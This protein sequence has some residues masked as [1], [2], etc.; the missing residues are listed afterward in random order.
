MVLSAK[1]T[2]NFSMVGV[3]WQGATPLAGIAVQVRTK[4]SS[5]K[6]TE[7]TDMSIDYT[8]T[9]K[10]NEPVGTDPY[11]VGPS[12]GV[13]VTVT[14]Q[15]GIKIN[16][17]KLT[18]I[19]P[20]KQSQDAVSAN[21]PPT[22]VAGADAAQPPV[23]SRAAW[24][25]DESLET[26]DPEYAPTIKAA[27]IHHTVDSNDYS[28]A[29]VPGMMRS[30]YYYHAVTRGW[31]DIGYNVVVDKFGHA[32]EGRTGGL[33][34]TVIGGH[35]GGF[36]YETFGVAMLG[37]YDQVQ[38]PGATMEMV[39]QLIAWK[40]SLYGV[41]SNAT[42]QLTQQDAAGTGRFNDGQTVTLPTIMGHR[43]VDLTACPG[44]FGYNILSWERLRV[45]QLNVN[46]IP[47]GSL[48]QVS[49]S[50]TTVQVSGWAIDPDSSSSPINMAVYDGS[51]LIGYQPTTQSRPDVN[52]AIGISGTHGFNF[53]FPQQAVGTH[54]YC[55]YG[56]DA[57]GWGNYLIGC[58]TIYVP[59]PT[60]SPIGHLDG[61]GSTL[62]TVSLSGWG[63]DPDTLGKPTSIAIYGPQGLVYWGP[64]DVNRPDV[65]SAFGSTGAHGFAISL[66]NQPPGV[67]TYCAYVADSA[68]YEN[69]PIG[70]AAVSNAVNR[71][72][73]GRIEGA[74]VT[75][76]TVS[77]S[78]W[79]FDPD[80]PN[81]SIYIATYSPAGLVSWITASLYRPDVNSVFGIAGQHGF[82]I[83]IPNQPVGSTQYCLY[84]ADDRGT[85]N[86][87]LGCTSVTVM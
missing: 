11:W 34:S 82:A 45:S 7:W 66:A 69:V 41:N 33:A 43:D 15:T 50:G 86:S 47:A 54:T 28:E 20:N 83:T 51:Q 5:G 75:A 40:F 26:W 23:Y 60:A 18:L 13:E 24:G 8:K 62:G 14:V 72:P 1:A 36:N 78:G 32:W 67:Q 27:V 63:L 73:T 59:N 80:T 21:S 48:E 65:N 44:Q 64:T 70:C 12:A 87:L 77:I 30:I 85:T 4:S 9:G 31:G 57:Q 81:A 58:S 38:V 68:G 79:A 53:S 16:G 22:A 3:T 29:D 56:Q 2:P 55:A 74:G 25:A 35:A 19:D 42:T 76:R 17:A 46:Q 10:A 61:S 49:N 39:A 6:W 84:G 71:M 52:S 37:D